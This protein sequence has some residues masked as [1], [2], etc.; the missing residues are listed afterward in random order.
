MKLLNQE[1]QK[2]RARRF[3]L[4]G[5]VISDVLIG[6]HGAIKPAEG[7]GHWPAAIVEHIPTNLLLFC[8]FHEL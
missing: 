2:H 6:C 5:F 8:P 4:M 3:F 7:V 1:V